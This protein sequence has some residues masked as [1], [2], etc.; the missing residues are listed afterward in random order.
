MRAIIV[1]LAMGGC[2]AYLMPKAS[3]ESALAAAA[4][5]TILDDVMRW[6][7]RSER[8]TLSTYWSLQFDGMSS[9]A[10]AD[11]M[12]RQIQRQYPDAVDSAQA[13]RQLSIRVYESQIYEDSAVVV[14]AF[15][16][17]WREPCR[18]NGTTYYYDYR[19]R[20]RG[21]QWQYVGREEVGVADPA[22]PR[23]PGSSC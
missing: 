23:S 9:R 2:S 8:D 21:Q 13:V 5:D 10:A 22:P 19:F 6:A 1:V 15:G 3:A 11:Q 7:P 14:T 20:R 17:G 12:V 16:Y 4:V 18:W